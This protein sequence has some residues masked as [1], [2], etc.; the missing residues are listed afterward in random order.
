MLGDS[1]I[2][3][4][5]LMAAVS[6]I[7]VA[8][9]VGSSV[10]RSHREQRH[11]NRL[12]VRPLIHVYKTF[13]RECGCAKIEVVNNGVGPAIL[14]RIEELRKAHNMMPEFEFTRKLASHVANEYGCGLK[15]DGEKF[16]KEYTLPPSGRFQIGGFCFYGEKK[17][18]ALVALR[19][20]VIKGVSYKIVYR[21]IYDV[22]SE[23]IDP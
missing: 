6:N 9:W 8:V 1:L 5:Q 2:V 3:S 22:R 4:L 7:T 11:H 19:G 18:D 15:C 16:E 23:E 17:D 21:T 13:D 14:E 12:S 10:V 20:K